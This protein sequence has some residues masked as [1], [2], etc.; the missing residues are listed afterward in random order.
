[1]QMGVI[2]WAREIL[3]YNPNREEQ[4]SLEIQPALA[5]EFPTPARCP[6]FSTLNCDRF[7]ES[8]R[9]RLPNWEAALRMAL[10]GVMK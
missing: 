10:E 3:R 2:E 5:S 7:A 4:I 9:L 8:F 1:M 6:L